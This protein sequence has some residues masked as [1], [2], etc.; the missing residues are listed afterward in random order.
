LIANASTVLKEHGVEPPSGL[1]V[2]IVENT[3]E[4]IHLTLP[5]KPREGE[6]S[7]DELENVAG[8][9]ASL[10]MGAAKWLNENCKHVRAITIQGREEYYCNDQP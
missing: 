8:G 5:A 1:Q 2:R 6:L 9:W 10:A 7:D 4:L 3:D